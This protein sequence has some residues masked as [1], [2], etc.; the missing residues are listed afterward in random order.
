MIRS[1]L[2]F[3]GVITARGGSKGIRG[4]NIY[5]VLGKPLIAY[6]IDAATK[7]QYLDDCIISTDSER[8][9]EIAIKW[10]GN[11][12]FLRPTEIAQDSTPSVDVLIHA[13]QWYEEHW[14]R[15][16]D[17]VVLLQPTAPMR[18]P[19]DIDNAIVKFKKGSA[20]SLFSCYEEKAAH[21]FVMYIEEHGLLRPLLFKE[22]VVMRRQEFPPVYVRNGAI[23]ISSRELLLVEKRIRD[24]RSILYLMPEERSV[25]IDEEKDLMELEW[26]LTRKREQS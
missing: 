11:V 19:E 24:D 2:F 1:K 17:A 10:G 23:Y 5:P 26:R 13:L 3:L 9:A 25:N 20:R 4:K 6:T 21:P 12:P 22:D 15:K 8:I 7:S 16:V 18:L 14:N